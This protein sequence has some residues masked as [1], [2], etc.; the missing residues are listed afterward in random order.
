VNSDPTKYGQILKAG[1]LCRDKKAPE[2]S[3]FTG[4][5]KRAKD[6]SQEFNITVKDIVIPEFCPILGIPL[7]KGD[8]KIHAGPPSLDKVDPSRGYVKG[9]VQVISYEAN[10]YTQDN[11]PKD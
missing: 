5:K 3:M 7:K 9:N 1:K 8:G 2:M 10:K 11:W 4:A 6:N